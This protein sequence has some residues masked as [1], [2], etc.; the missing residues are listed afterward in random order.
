MEFPKNLAKLRRPACCSP[1]SIFVF[2]HGFAVRSLTLLL[3][4]LPRPPPCLKFPWFCLRGET[5]VFWLKQTVQKQTDICI[6]LVAK[7]LCI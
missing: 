4:A 6:F 2:I 7:E 1:S 3:A 5:F